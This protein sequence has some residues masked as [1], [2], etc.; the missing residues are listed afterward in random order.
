M[1]RYATPPL[2]ADVERVVILGFNATKLAI[3]IAIAELGGVARTSDI[4]P[5]VPTTKAT[6]LHHLRELVDAG[7]VSVDQ[8]VS[9]GIRASWTIHPDRLNADLQALMKAWTPTTQPEHER[10]QDR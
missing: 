5:R 8:P 9:A 1:P 10:Q 4:A 2:P 6:L 7:Y 3:L